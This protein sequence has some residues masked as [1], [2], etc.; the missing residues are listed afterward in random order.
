MTHE[1]AAMIHAYLSEKIAFAED[2]KQAAEKQG[3]HGRRLFFE[4]QLDELLVIR[5]YL[6]ENVDLNTQQYY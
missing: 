5:K 3:D 4:G 1:Y 2:K 6:S